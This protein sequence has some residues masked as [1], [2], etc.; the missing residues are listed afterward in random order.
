MSDICG[1]VDR[2]VFRN[3]DTGYCVARFQLAEAGRQNGGTTTIVGT[4]PSIRTGEM[5]RLTGEWQIHP[6]HG[7]NFR[8]ERFEEELPTTS[9][10][11][12]RYLGSGAVRGIGPVTARRIV[13]CF[14]DR[15]IAVIDEE[16]ELLRRVAGISARRLQII[17]ESWAEQSQ[18]R[19]LS[20]FL[21]EH[22]IS[23]GLAHRIHGVYGGEAPIIIRDDPYR[24]AQDVHGVGFR[25]ADSVARLL[26]VP[27]DSVSRYVAGLKFELGRA[28]E[29]GHVFLLREELLGRASKLLDASKPNL[30]IALLELLRRRGAIL[31]GDSVYLVQFY[32][33]ERRA[34]ELLRLL[35]AEPSALSLDPR[36]DA[37]HSIRSAAD[38]QG[39]ILADKQMLAAESVLREKITILTGGPGTGK[40]STLRTVISALESLSLSFC[41]CAPTGRAAKRV[42]EATGRPASTIHR[43]L[44]FQP[45]SNSFHYDQHRPLPYDFVIVDEVSMLD[46]LLF[47]HLL[48]AVPKEAQLVFVGDSDQLPSVGPGNV[49]RDLITSAQIPTVTL[50]ELFRQAKNSRIV[51]AAHEINQGRVP[52]LD[53]R[54]ESDFFF[55][56]AEHDDMALERIKRLVCERI[57]ATFQLDPI[58]DVQVLSP[59]HAGP[60]GVTSLN[61]ELQQLLNP[62]DLSRAE[63]LRGSG[64]FRVGDKV[65]QI[66]N[67]YDKDVYNGDVGRILT[68]DQAGQGMVVGFGASA[69]AIEIEYESGEL[70]ELVLAYA[71]S[72]H[73]SQ[74]SEFPAI[75]LP[76][77]TAHYILLQRNL[78]YTAI[79]R[80]RQLCVIVGSKRAFEIAVR[81][82]HRVRRNTAL[83]AR[84]QSLMASTEAQLL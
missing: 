10:G 5:L 50:T 55:V 4:L 34:A 48:K 6:T 19:E 82:N 28:T 59:M 22:G 13:E 20:L 23:V 11:I 47:Y 30:E 71:V 46:T 77:V 84:L 38:A 78:I 80:A 74:G 17:R 8:V 37:G 24:L 62:P 42:A 3:T 49:L 33:A 41:L 43:L 67:N 79:T 66:R 57:P 26:G 32:R 12:E 76:L 27:S 44:E 58:E 54:P 16:P 52:A 56:P 60:V 14:G 40:T 73:K 15:T 25:T 69:N 9:E 29:E 68:I 18:V 72:V 81:T 36:F 65:M 31:D 45:S 64:L 2:I 51:L 21:Q 83:A 75:V 39:L 1:S 63:L 61:T 7:R 53:N 70:D 35:A